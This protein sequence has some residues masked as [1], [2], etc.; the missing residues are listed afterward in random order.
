MNSS[1]S[2]PD[3]IAEIFRHRQRA[4]GNAQTR[5]RWFVHLAKHHHG[6]IDHM[7]AGL[8]DLRFLHFQPKISPFASALTHARKYRITTVLLCDTRDQ[9][10]NNDRLAQP[11][12]A[13]QSR[14]TTAKKRRQQIDHLNAG[15][16]HLR[17]RRKILKFRRFAMD[18]PTPLRHHR[19]TIINRIPQQ[20]KH[21]P[22]RFF[23]H[24]HRHRRPVS[25]TSTPRRSP[26]VDPNATARIFPPPRCC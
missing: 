20:I 8:T 10:L 11:R 4:E 18:R 21:P 2:A 15:F 13:E 14:L 16:K 12:P 25:I 24:R 6:L 1:V 22:Q 17:L 23:P 26:S 7:L 9:F 19:P 3:L 5:T